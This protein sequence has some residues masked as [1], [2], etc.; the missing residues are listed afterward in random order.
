MIIINKKPYGNED[1][2]QLLKNL[3]L[4]KEAQNEGFYSF[5]KTTLKQILIKAAS[6]NKFINTKKIILNGNNNINI[7]NKAN[8][9]MNEH[10][11]E[12]IQISRMS[13]ELKISESNLYKIFQKN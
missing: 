12:P 9:W 1:I 5:A 2:L 4:G 10:I 6:E 7:I 8:E 3:A 13:K 11:S